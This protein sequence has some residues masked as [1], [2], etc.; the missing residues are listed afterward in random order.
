MVVMKFG[1]VIDDDD[2]DDDDDDNDDD[3]D[4]DDVSEDMMD[5]SKRSGGRRSETYI[6][7]M[8]IDGRVRHLSLELIM[9]VYGCNIYNQCR[10]MHPSRL[11]VIS[12]RVRTCVDLYILLPV[13]LS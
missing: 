5:D 11:F 2:D 6:H 9:S 3:D 10:L 13:R 8:A 1:G 4:G 12:S 7:G